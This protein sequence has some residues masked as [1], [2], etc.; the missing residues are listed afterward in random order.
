MAE[1][2]NKNRVLLDLNNEV[3]QE[4]WLGCG[5]TEILLSARLG[6]RTDN[7]DIPLMNDLEIGSGHRLEALG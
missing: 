2:R 5:W 1:D 6:S 3:F 4:N 7:K